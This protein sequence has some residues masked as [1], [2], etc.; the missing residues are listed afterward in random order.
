MYL[1]L[2]LA[3]SRMFLTRVARLS[4]M[5][6]FPGRSNN[7]RNS[8]R[9]RKLTTAAQGELDVCIV[10]GGIGG[11]ALALAI[12]RN[13]A[14]GVR[15]REDD[16]PITFKSM[17]RDWSH[18]ARRQGYGLTLNR[19]WDSLERLGLA[20]LARA[21]DTPS[22]A[23]YIFDGSGH[24]LNVFSSKAFG[25]AG[26]SAG[27]AAKHLWE[28]RRNLIIPRQRLRDLLL[29]E[30]SDS[31]HS[32]AMEW[33]WI[34]VGHD[35]RPDGRV[36]VSFQRDGEGGARER[37][38]VIARVLVGAD[39]LWSGVRERVLASIRVSNQLEYLGV[40]VV[41]GIAPSSHPLCDGNT[42]QV[43][44]PPHFSAAE[45]SFPLGSNYLCMALVRLCLP[46]IGARRRDAALQYAV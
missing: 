23:H 41:L 6:I 21:E 20:D 42:F 17:E 19:G 39:G 43:R 37:R 4:E 9:A 2:L 10:G 31:G 15:W 13:N 44:S 3:E 29:Q 28:L 8:S 33:G 1:E 25:G 26:G 14:H 46:C 32:S 7:F 5:Y 18:S 22:N 36:A 12:A 40:L 24:L 27:A 35:H 34:Y 11:V 38:T 16:R 30:L 45:G